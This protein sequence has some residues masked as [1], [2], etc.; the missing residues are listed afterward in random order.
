MS[1]PRVGVLSREGRNTR[2]DAQVAQTGRKG[3]PTIVD[4]D[5]IH[6]LDYGPTTTRV[7]EKQDPAQEIG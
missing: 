5:E 6:T 3:M 7:E 2:T 1:P 4:V